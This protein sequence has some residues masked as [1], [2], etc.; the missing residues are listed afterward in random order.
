MHQSN[1]VIIDARKA[2]EDLEAAVAELMA[3]YNEELE[4][5]QFTE[6]GEIYWRNPQGKW[7]WYQLGGR[8][9]GF[10]DGYDPATDPAN[11]EGVCTLCF[12]TGKDLHPANAAIA[13][14]YN[15]CAGCRGTGNRPKW[16]TEWKLYEGDL[17]PIKALTQEHV[18][19]AAAVVAE[20]LGFVEQEEF[21][22]VP[23]GESRFEKHA[24]PTADELKERYPGHLVAIVDSH[25]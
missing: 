4:V 7:D 23:D 5:E 20:G 1:L 19:N 18:N 24:L 17:I 2:T 8:W 12:G 9:T 3:P 10:F 25:S 11:I 16:P 14:E 21:V 15:G 6:D 13:A 22:Y